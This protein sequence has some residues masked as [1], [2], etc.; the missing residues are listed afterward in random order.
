MTHGREQLLDIE[1]LR[2]ETVR[3]LPETGFLRLDALVGT[4]DIDL[5]RRAL[6]LE[7]VEDTQADFGRIEHRGHVQIEDR[8]DRL[9]VRRVA[10]G[11]WEVAR[12]RHVVLVAER[13]VKLLSDG[14]FVV[15]D[16]KFRFQRLGFLSA[17]FAS[18]SRARL[19]STLKNVQL[20]SALRTAYTATR[21]P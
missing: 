3:A 17:T 11:G 9:E 21:V 6:L 13:P 12:G 5:R 16:K 19:S 18:L 4:D 1:R 8:D 20:A 2:Q 15:N 14:G 10:D 7:I